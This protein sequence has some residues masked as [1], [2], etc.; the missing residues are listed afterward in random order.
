M[1][2]YLQTWN[3]RTLVHKPVELVI[4]TD[5]SRKGWRGGGPFCQRDQHRRPLVL[6]R[7]ET[8]HQLPQT[9]SGVISYQDLHKRQG[10]RTC[11]AANGQYS[12]CSIHKQ[13]GKPPISGAIK[14][15]FR[16]LEVVHPPPNGRFGATSVGTYKHKSRQGIHAAT[17][18][19]RLE[20]KIQKC[21]KH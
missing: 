4:E 8:S 17:R 13:D 12:S 10:L 20:A 16:S 2:G 6:R 5:A 14:F 11:K 18:L 19:Q 21:L 3:G 9:Y 7:K 15:S 1:E